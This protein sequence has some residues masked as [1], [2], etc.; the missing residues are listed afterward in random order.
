VSMVSMVSMRWVSPSLPAY[1]RM[2]A[3]TSSLTTTP[4]RRRLRRRLRRR[5]WR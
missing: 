5:R 1:S 2:R 3:E 4:A